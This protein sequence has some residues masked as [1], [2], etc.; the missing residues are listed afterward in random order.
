MLPTDWITADARRA[1]A[2]VR[3]SDREK[4]RLAII[5]LHYGEARETAACLRSILQADAAGWEVS[6]IVVDNSPEENLPHC[7]LPQGQ[8]H[9]VRTGRNLG[10]A[11]GMNTGMR[12]ALAENAE[13]FLLLNN[14]LVLAPD[15]LSG[16]RNV[17]EEFPNAGL[18]G[19][20]IFL[21]SDP[22]RVWFGGGFVDALLGRTRHRQ[23][24]ALDSEADDSAIPVDYIT[25]AML[26]I[27]RRVLRVVG[28]LNEAMFLYFEDAEY[29]LRARAKGFSPVYTPRVRA[30]H[31]VGALLNNQPSAEYLYYQTRNRWY[32]LRCAGGAVYR[33]YLLLIHVCGYTVL[34][35]LWTFVHNPLRNARRALNILYGGVDSLRGKTGPNPRE[36]R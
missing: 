34:R 17:V 5:V 21:Q 28:W 10:Y 30:W 29:G 12:L 1:H 15:A 3:L 31:A 24:Q 4:L 7:A 36:G 27:H 2:G 26:L 35:S 22:E 11:G 13:Y 18:Y 14:D 19:G 8:F 9:L 16:F 33:C 32:A 23:Y 20:K 6:I 25:G